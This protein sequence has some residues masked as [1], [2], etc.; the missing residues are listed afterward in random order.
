MTVFNRGN[1]GLAVR[2]SSSIPKVFWPVLIEGTEYVDGG[3]TSRVPVAVAR[4]MGGQIVIA[5]DVSWRGSHEAQAADV[6]IRPDRPRTRTLD[7]SAK[8]ESIAAGE[9]AAGAMLPELRRLL[10]QAMHKPAPRLPR[11]DG[12]KA[13]AKT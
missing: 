4:S 6:V 3:L 1:T 7:F 10:E 8:M 9:E 13:A 5:V 11:P 12:G 2:A